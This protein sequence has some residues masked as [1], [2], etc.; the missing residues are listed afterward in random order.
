[1]LEYVIEIDFIDCPGLGYK[2]FAL[3]EEYSIDKIS[4]E[5]LPGCGMVIKFR[6]LSKSSVLKQKPYHGQ[7]KRI[8]RTSCMRNREVVRAGAMDTQ[9]D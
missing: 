3:T 4:M 6:C 1:M 5:V 7:V 9:G 8:S 2:I